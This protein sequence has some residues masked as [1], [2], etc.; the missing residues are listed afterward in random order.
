MRA[1]ILAVSLVAMASVVGGCRN[2][3]AVSTTDAAAPNRFFVE[4]V[5]AHPT[6]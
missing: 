5:V 1:V 3:P 2:S 4:Q 6:P